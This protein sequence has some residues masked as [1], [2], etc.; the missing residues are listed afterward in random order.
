MGG[1]GSWLSS[2]TVD[3]QTE[4]SSSWQNASGLCPLSRSEI[5]EARRHGVLAKMISTEARRPAVLDKI[6]KLSLPDNSPIIV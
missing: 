4:K 1:G 3:A 5:G 6:A 2:T